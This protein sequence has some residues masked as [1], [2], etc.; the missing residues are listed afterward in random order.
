M[1]SRLT[2][3]RVMNLAE[4]FAGSARKHPDKIALCW[5]DREI[6]YREMLSLAQGVA[7]RLRSEFGVQPGDRVAVWMKNC[8]EFVPAVFGILTAGGVV[9]PVNNFL[10]PAEVA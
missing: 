1:C 3:L 5:G 7:A 10:K 6:P 2:N 4:A 9:V 8:P